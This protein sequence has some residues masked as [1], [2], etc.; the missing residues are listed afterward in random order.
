MMFCMK[1]KD[2]SVRVRIFL[3]LLV[4]LHFFLSQA[5]HCKVSLFTFGHVHIKI[6]VLYIDKDNITC[7]RLGVLCV[8]L[9]LYQ[10]HSFFFTLIASFFKFF[11][12]YREEI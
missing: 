2:T 9:E 10:S 6:Q 12:A 11:I 5:R 1:H 8:C 3:F 4:H 7:C